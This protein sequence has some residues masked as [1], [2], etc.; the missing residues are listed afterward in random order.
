MDC[1]NPF[2]LLKMQQVV[3][4]VQPSH[5]LQGF[6][7]PFTM[8]PHSDQIRGTQILPN[9]HVCPSK[10]GELVDGGPDVDVTVSEATRPQIL[11]VARQDRPIMRHDHAESKAAHEFGVRQMLDHFANGPLAGSLGPRRDLRGHRVKESLESGW[12]LAQDRDR[13][14]VTEQVKKS[15]NVGGDV[16]RGG[17]SGIAEDAHGV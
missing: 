2:Q 3:A 1:A 4:G 9:S 8:D 13:V 11:I 10:R 7:T 17:R 6:L 15:G 5:V 14:I 12:G 16:G